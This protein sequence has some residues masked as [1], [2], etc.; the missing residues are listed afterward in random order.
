MD[1]PSGS[2]IYTHHYDRDEEH[3]LEEGI[4]SIS[5]TLQEYI[6]RRSY[7][8]KRTDSQGK[9]IEER[10]C[11][12]SDPVIIAEIK[13]L[14]V[15]TTMLLLK[16]RETDYANEVKKL[17]DYLGAYRSYDAISLLKN[18]LTL[19]EI[20]AIVLGDKHNFKDRT[21]KQ[22]AWEKEVK[23]KWHLTDLNEKDEQYFQN[24]PTKWKKM[25]FLATHNM[26]NCDGD[27]Y[28]LVTGINNGGKTNTS[29]A[30]LSF[31]NRL[32]REYWKVKNERFSLKKDVY[33]VPAPTDLDELLGDTM[34]N[35]KDLNEGMAAAVNLRS[36]DPQVIKLGVNAFITRAK[37]NFVIFE[38]QVASRV[39][40]LLEERFNLWIHK[41]SKEWAVMSI[42]SSLYR[43]VDPLYLDELDKLRSDKE[44]SY[45]FRYKNPN[46]ITT[47]RAPKL[48]KSFEEKFKD[49]QKKAHLTTK[50][51]SETN[52]L[53]NQSYWL[54][55]KRMWDR[56]NMEHRLALIELPSILRQE[57]HYSEAQV[58]SFMRDYNK[59]DRE[60]K[61]L[62]WE[63]DA[64]VETAVASDSVA[65]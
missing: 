38:Y 26:V 8:I 16:Y 13:G 22:F 51:A 42:P 20:V 32:L 60:H 2:L 25:V 57:V 41:M 64:G 36:M 34:Y 28:A 27:I 37:H 50:L 65:E 58:K 49:Y 3:A 59:Y 23:K 11:P 17:E 54:L 46:Y 63:R 19:R 24:L 18:V 31:A 35:T 52:M 14:A 56:I 30:L 45:W 47:F 55:I 44:I 9:E 21:E 48:K 53:V 29:L 5:R 43:K 6:T 4:V 40:K 1:Q 62:D 61:L 33:Y 15:D 7:F 39:P 10:V 12:I